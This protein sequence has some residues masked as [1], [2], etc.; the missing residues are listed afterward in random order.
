MSIIAVFMS[1][2]FALVGVDT[3]APTP[4]GGLA[5]ISKLIPLVHMNAVIAYRG[6]AMFL[7]V[8]FAACHAQ[9]GSADTLIERLPR[10]LTETSG[11]FVHQ[12]RSMGISDPE[13]LEV[14]DVVFV[15][16]SDLAACMVCHAYHQECLKD[17][18][19]DREIESWFA[20]PW[21][22]SRLQMP[23]TRNLD[24]LIEVA[25]A[26]VQLI[27]TEAPGATAGGRLISALIVK[28]RMSISSV[29]NLGTA[30]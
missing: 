2:Q 25:N 28:D 18:F 29:A 16:W 24:D 9:G 17:G 1:R 10:I 15:G 8:L 3:A 27:R 22:S 7:E 12:A 20:A 14:H 26:Q 23:E 11:A 21:D 6:C 5:D 30:P 13:L 19:A 4:S